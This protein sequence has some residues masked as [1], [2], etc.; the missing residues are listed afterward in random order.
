MRSATACVETFPLV[1]DLLIAAVE[2]APEPGRVVTPLLRLCARAHACG[3]RATVVVTLF[4]L[5]EITAFKGD[6]P[7]AWL[8]GT[9]D[10]DHE[11][12]YWLRQLVRRWVLRFGAA[13]EGVRNVI[14]ERQEELFL[15]RRMPV[16]EVLRLHASEPTAA[17]WIAL[18]TRRDE[19][20]V[21]PLPLSFG[22]RCDDADAA[23]RDSL[24]R[25]LDAGTHAVLERW[26]SELSG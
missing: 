9:G 20:V 10:L 16:H 7:A 6:A 4:T 3:H 23:L 1:Q 11:A 22:D 13:N 26:L 17:G 14:R 25:R 15:E 21:G 8:A 2:L 19:L 18:G 5:A 12:A 24:Q